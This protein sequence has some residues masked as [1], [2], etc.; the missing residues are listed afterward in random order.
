V[1]DAYELEAHYV[2]FFAGCRRLSGCWRGRHDLSH[3]HGAQRSKVA[4]TFRWMSKKVAT[5]AF[6]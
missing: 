3:V 6:M 4:T 1:R 2:S 5:H